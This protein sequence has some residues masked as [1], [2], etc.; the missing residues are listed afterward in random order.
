LTAIGIP[1]SAG[2]H[3]SGS[4]MQYFYHSCSI[5]FTGIAL[6]GVCSDNNPEKIIEDYVVSGN[7]KD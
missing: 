4:S 6:N 1:D 5:F 7:E 3:A 2:S